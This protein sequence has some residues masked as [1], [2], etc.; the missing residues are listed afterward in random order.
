MPC[1]ERRRDCRQAACFVQVR[2]TL[3]SKHMATYGIVGKSC[4]ILAGT[5]GMVL[6]VS[7]LY[8]RTNEHGPRAA[9][10]VMV[11]NTHFRADREKY[12]ARL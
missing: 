11:S 4:R 9:A 12:L 5:F 7:A 3:P 6:T 8:A 1:P 2:S 10:L